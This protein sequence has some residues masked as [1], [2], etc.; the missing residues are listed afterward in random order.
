MCFCQ[1]YHF[2]ADLFCSAVSVAAVLPYQVVNDVKAFI[3]DF[4]KP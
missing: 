1:L 2:L 3:K 4:M